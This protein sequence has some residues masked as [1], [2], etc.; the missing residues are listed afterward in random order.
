MCFKEQLEYCEALWQRVSI[1]IYSISAYA[2]NS[3]RHI[4]PKC[5]TVACETFGVKAMWLEQ[6]CAPLGRLVA[7]ERK[8]MRRFIK[9]EVSKSEIQRHKS[10][11]SRSATVRLS[12]LTPRDCAAVV[13]QIN[14]SENVKTILGWLV[15]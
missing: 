13:T 2:V 10:V 12:R 11:S 3:Q 6:A 7:P 15:C 1:K 4:S 5:Q 8:W 9:M 14:E